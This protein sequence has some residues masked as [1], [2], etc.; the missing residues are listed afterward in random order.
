MSLVLLFRQAVASALRRLRVSSEVGLTHS[1][2]AVLDETNEA[3]SSIGLSR[4]A[5]AEV[6]V[7]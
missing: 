7:L 1:A 5:I 6:T 2:A 3:A 4:Q